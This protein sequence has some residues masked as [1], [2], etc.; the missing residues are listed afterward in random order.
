MRIRR[1]F[2]TAT[3]TC[4]IAITM[5]ATMTTG[6]RHNTANM[7]NPKVA[8]AVTLLD[9]SNTTVTIADGLTA[10]DKILDALRATEPDYYKRTRPLLVKIAKLN[11][12]ASAA[13]VKAK[14]GDTNANW[15]IAMI[16]I[17]QAVATSDL[18]TFGFK[19]RNSQL[20]VQDGFAVLISGL[21]LAGQFGGGK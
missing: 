1:R 19:N 5:T 4:L 17:S 9:A 16:N 14:N 7:A 10:A 13:I 15:R 12:I 20:A 6:C 18:T 2:I 3:M 11:D 21:T 8:M